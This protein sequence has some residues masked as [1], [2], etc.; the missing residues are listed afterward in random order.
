MGAPRLP[1]WVLRATWLSSLLDPL[2]D[3]EMEE[4]FKYRA[5]T[6]QGQERSGQIRGR[7][8]AAA[9]RQLI[10]QGLTPIRIEGVGLSAPGSP[11]TRV[12]RR[13]SRADLQLLLEEFATLLRSGISLGEALPSMARAY[14]RHPLGAALETA[15]QRVR[16]GGQLSDAL[17]QPGLKWPPYALALVRAGEASGDLA[18]AMQSAADQF[19]RELQGTRELRSA[20]V[21]PAILVVAGVAAVL[22]VFVGVVPRFAPVLKSTRGEVPELSRSVIEFGVFLQANLQWVGIAALVVASIVG[23]VFSQAA[24]RDAALAAA[25]RLPLVGTWIRSADLGR[26]A[27]T[28]GALLASRVPFLDALAL[29]SGVLRL[30]AMRESLLANAPQLKQ[31]KPLSEILEALAW[32]PDIRVNL[33][34]VGERS[35]ELPKMLAALGRAELEKASTLQRRVLTLIEPAAILLIGGVIGF[36]MVAVMMAITSFNSVVG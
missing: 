26:W 24:S 16:A 28:L 22:V 13:A 2:A 18:P 34:R 15:H 31:G 33:V 19:A 6:A 14:A 23:L 11:A 30:R 21:Y 10:S 5:T 17:D 29:S 3:R 7:D 1:R 20:L 9:A 35:G 27:E 8:A 25:A 12:A 4:V 36:I 32:F